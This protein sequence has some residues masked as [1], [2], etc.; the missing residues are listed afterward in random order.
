MSR[1]RYTA[2]DV[3]GLVLDAGTFRS[4]DEALDGA[5]PGQ[6]RADD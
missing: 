3:I 1:R 4:W 6:A 5:G 2:A